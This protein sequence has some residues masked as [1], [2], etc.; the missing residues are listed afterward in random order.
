MIEE[1]QELL[2]GETFE[3]GTIVE[4][5]PLIKVRV[6]TS[7]QPSVVVEVEEGSTTL[8]CINASGNGEHGWERITINGEPAEKY[9]EVHDGDVVILADKVKGA[10]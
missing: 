6:K 10:F 3:N 2:D 9:S 8:D 7:G 5:L 4:E 1:Q